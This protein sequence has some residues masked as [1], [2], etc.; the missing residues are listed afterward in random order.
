MNVKFPRFQVLS[1]FWNLRIR[2]NEIKH[3]FSS[4]EELVTQWRRYVGKQIQC[5]K[6]YNGG[7][8][9]VTGKQGRGR[10]GRSPQSGWGDLLRW[11]RVFTIH[12]V[13]TGL[14][15]ESVP[16]TSPE[17]S[18]ISNITSFMKIFLILPTRFDFSCLLIFMACPLNLSPRFIPVCILTLSCQLHFVLTPGLPHPCTLCVL[19]TQ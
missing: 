5:S 14:P 15:V 6:W 18:R 4:Q 2:R 3:G 10:N 8:F 17:I 19:D 11:L 13:L 1:I 7:R 9:T 16:V 12:H